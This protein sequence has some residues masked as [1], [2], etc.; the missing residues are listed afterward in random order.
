MGRGWKNRP[1]SSWWQMTTFS[2]I[3]IFLF[4]F[5]IKR[6]PPAGI[7]ISVPSARRFSTTGDAITQKYQ[8]SADSLL[9][10]ATCFLGPLTLLFATGNEGTCYQGNASALPG[11]SMRYLL[12]M[13]P[14]E[15]SKRHVRSRLPSFC[16]ATAVSV[17]KVPIVTNDFFPYRSLHNTPFYG[18]LYT[19]SRASLCVQRT[20]FNLSDIAVIG[21]VRE[22][23]LSRSL[24]HGIIYFDK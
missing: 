17:S 6:I 5:S 24:I 20:H 4:S 8:T 21:I 1:S 10:K 22:K 9:R 18:F 7:F 14:I 15:K 19:L 2:H 13:I 16:L 12:L 3:C 11:V 23:P